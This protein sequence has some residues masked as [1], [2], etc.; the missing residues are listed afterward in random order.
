MV[1]AE[2]YSQEI[3]HVKPTSEVFP[4]ADSFSLNTTAGN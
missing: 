1:V 4:R 2:L 3:L